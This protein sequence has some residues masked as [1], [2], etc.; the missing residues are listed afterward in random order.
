MESW[1]RRSLLEFPDVVWKLRRVW[2]Q[3][4]SGNGNRDGDEADGVSFMSL[5]ETDTRATLPTS[6]N[7]LLGETYAESL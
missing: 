3:S 1:L 7:T 4:Y 5:G 6:P 2:K